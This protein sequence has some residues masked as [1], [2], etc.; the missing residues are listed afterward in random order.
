M[1]GEGVKREG[2][3]RGGCEEGRGMRRGGCGRGGYEEGRERG[4][5]W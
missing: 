3:G 1:A 5:V 2:C 4:E